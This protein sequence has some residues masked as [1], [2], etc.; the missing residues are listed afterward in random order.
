MS[1]SRFVYILVLILFLFAGGG[2]AI[3]NWDDLKSQLPDQL[4][5]FTESMSRK[6]APTYE[7]VKTGFN[8]LLYGSK[9]RITGPAKAPVKA[10][11]KIVEAPIGEAPASRK[12][13]T[14]STATAPR[15]GNVRLARE[16]GSVFSGTAEPGAR[17]TVEANGRR[18]G[19]TKAN[20]KGDWV[21]IIEEPMR[22]KK[23]S[24]GLMAQGPGGEGKKEHGA[25]ASITFAP[26]DGGN[27]I[28]SFSKSGI[29][30]VATRLPPVVKSGSLP[31]KKA[32]D[33]KQVLEKK[34]AEAISTL[35]A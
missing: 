10:T 20:R 30:T 1:G 6:A 5:S 2:Y 17:V 3:A 9:D 21:L 4:V 23:Y 31:D 18:L 15:F 28:V 19:R 34:L 27:K 14:S 12:P 16:G 29:A 35:F 26:E 11:R 8:T 25:G 7:K 13:I 33:K 32:L 22:E 24:F